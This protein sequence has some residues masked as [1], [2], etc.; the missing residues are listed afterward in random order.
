M[1]RSLA[2]AHLIELG[3][4]AMAIV[5]AWIFVPAAA[6]AWLARVAE[7][8]IA[9]AGDF[10][11]EA[12]ARRACLAFTAGAGLL[13]LARGWVLAGHPDSLAAPLLVPAAVFAALLGL[14]L[15]AATVET[16]FAL[17]GGHRVQL[18]RPTG[19]FEF[20][21]GMLLGSVLAALIVAWRGDPADLARRAQ[22]A[23]VVLIGGVFAALAVMGTGP[24]ASDARINLGPLQP[25][26]AVKPAVVAFLAAY[27]GARLGKLR[28]QRTSILGLR[29]PRPR[30]LV[31]ALL[32][33]LAT[34]AGLYVVGDLGPTLILALVFLGMF[35][36][37]SRASGWALLGLI[38]IVTMLATLALWPEL[39]GSG[40]VATRIAMWRDPWQNGLPYGHQVGEGLWAIASG[41]LFGQGLGQVHT[42]L[43]P[44]G[45][46]DLVLG[47][48]AEQLGMVGLIAYIVLIACVVLSGLHIAAHNRTPER[49]L[50]AAGLSLVIVV[51]WLVIAGGTFGLLP[52]TGV[53]VP[54]LSTGKSSMIAFMLMVGIVARLGQN[55]R[56][57]ASSDELD[58]VRGG[59]LPLA[60]FASLV[61]LIG[62]AAAVWAGPWRGSEV[63]SRGIVVRLADGTL[64]HRQNPRLIALAAQVRRG[65]IVDREGRPLAHSPDPKQRIYPLGSHM[66]TLIGAY[67]SRV[68]R[69]A[70]ALEG[71]FD[72]HLRGYGE[73]SGGPTYGDFGGTSQSPLPWPDL[74][75]FV[76]LLYMDR[77]ERARA[78]AAI[79][80]DID[81]R[82]TRLTIDARLQNEVAAILAKRVA[83]LSAPAAAAVVI[84]VDTGQVLAR[85]QIPDL[86]PAD[87]SWQQRLARGEDG[88]ATEHYGIYG[89]GSDRTG[90]LG[91]FQAGSVA[92]LF[93]ALAAARRGWQVRGRGCAVNADLQYACTE[94]DEQGPVFGLADWASPIHDHY[95]DR[96][97]GQIGVVTA[98]AVSCNVFFGQLG[99]ALGPEP[100]RQL[101]EAGADI[102]YQ[103]GRIPFRPGKAGSRQLASTAFGQ[104]AMAMNV[105]QVARLTAAIGAGGVYRRCPGTLELDAACEEIELVSDPR[106]VAPILAGMERVMTGGTGARL[107]AVPGVRIYGKTGTADSPLVRGEP[108]T[109]SNRKTPPPH[110]WF[111]ALFEASDEIGCGLDTPGRLAVVV[112]IP[113]AGS[114]AG[115][116][117]PAV[118]EIARA[119][120]RLG[121]LG[122]HE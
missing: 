62:V 30:L 94:R 49:V 24:G 67:P 36:L 22:P 80:G 106:L 82:S 56:V 46:T 52:L 120:Q 26:E 47:V 25:I 19:A 112:V 100:F 116:A 86:D 8:G 31:P 45:M 109:S 43:P 50:L 75:Q 21:Q 66:G 114:G 121:Y 34:F 104:G 7:L 12:H 13:A 108:T 33:L 40:R 81:K 59:I 38:L 115:A 84:D 122:G 41:G 16:Y 90:V 73:R 117:G 98:L 23:L 28:W 42:P 55:A 3:L 20:S 29:W 39:A 63:A 87:E 68:L 37:A 60:A 10:D 74:R 69:P 15:H 11:A 110:S 93:T 99:L 18:A 64:L 17:E 72:H 32:A 107:E 95:K 65:A 101:A 83:E 5:C 79:D 6:D 92:K 118:I 97:H 71:R 76:P 78:L 53:V 113:R 48:L 58:Q 44:A 91:M 70:W 35:Y 4:F 88:F 89:P 119:A 1:R 96:V 51:Q 14:V 9:V 111:T 57:R 85:A 105:L 103:G 102:G 77:D 61:L 2:P 27:L 54:F